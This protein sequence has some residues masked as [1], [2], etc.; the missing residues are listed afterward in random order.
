MKDVI[1]I[2]D[3]AMGGDQMVTSSSRNNPNA[4]PERKGK[5]KVS[6]NKYI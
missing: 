5:I 4:A 6:H 3:N 2:Q 1:D